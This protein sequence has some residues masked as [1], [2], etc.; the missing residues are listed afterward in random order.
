MRTLLLNPYRVAAAA[1]AIEALVAFA[2]FGAGIEGMQALARYSGRA[3]M[4][5]FA[6]IFAIAPWHQLARSETTKL[7]LRQR[8][9]LG[10]AFGSH[11]LA[12]L[13]FLLTYNAAAGNEIAL[14]RAAVGI[15]GYVALVVMMA[16]STKS[17]IARLGAKNWKKLHRICLWYLWTVFFLTYA[18]RLAG[19]VPNPGGGTFEYVVCVS[20]VLGIAVLRI[21]AFATRRRESSPVLAEV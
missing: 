7:A 19:K 8:R 5:W 20:L 16:T 14:E 1:L 12:H 6:L 2:S 10:L 4:V 15:A 13:A 21:A 18:S 17:A 9:H 3:G 11:H